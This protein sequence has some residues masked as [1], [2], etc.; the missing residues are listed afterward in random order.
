M[1]HQ[2]Y[3]VS[4]QQKSTSTLYGSVIMAAYDLRRQGELHY[5]GLLITIQQTANNGLAHCLYD[6]LIP[7]VVFFFIS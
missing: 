4:R 2:F 7:I 5:N 3:P 1:A 6:S